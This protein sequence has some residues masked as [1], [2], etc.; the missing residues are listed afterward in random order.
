M[1]NSLIR[2]RITTDYKKKV[3][4]VSMLIEFISKFAKNFTFNS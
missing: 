2:I 1:L 3:Q 4:I